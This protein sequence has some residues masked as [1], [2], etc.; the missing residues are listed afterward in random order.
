MKRKLALLLSA[1]MA[2]SCLPMTAYAANF[3]DIN[4]VPWS[5]AADV[6]NSVADLG[7]LSG[8]EDGT[9]RSRNN[10]TYCE[11]M[12]MVYNVLIK[13]GAA[14]AMDAVDAYSYM[15]VLN[16][17]KVPSWCQMAVAY[18]LH[19]GIID[20]QMVATKFSG[21]NQAATRE[22]VALIFGNAMAMFYD[23][24]KDAATAKEFLDYYSISADSLVQIDLLKRLGI[25]SGDETNRFNP[26]KNIN[27]AEMAVMLNKTNSVLTEGVSASG[28]ITELVVNENKYYYIEVT[29]D[30]GGREGFQATLGEF[31]VYVGNTSETISLSKLSEGDEVVLVRSGNNVTALRQLKGTTNQGKYD[32]TGYIISLKNNVLSFE[33]ENTGETTK[34]TLKSGVNI[35]VEGNK[36]TRAQLD[37]LLSERYNEHAYA[38]ANTSV[39]REKNNGVYEDVTYIEEL[40]V[41]FT[42]EYVT[43]GEVK[44]FGLKSISVKP[45]GGS[46][47]KTFTFASD[48]EFYIGDSKET[49]SDLKELNDGGTTY[50]KVTVNTDE[51]A[52]KV[53]MSEDAFEDSQKDVSKTYKVKTLTDKKL[54]LEAGGE[55]TTYV[56]GTTNPL[57]N[58]RFYEW[59]VDEDD[60]DDSD[61]QELKNVDK[62]EAFVDDADGT[63]YCKIVFNSG[64]KLSEVY[65]SEKKSAWDDSDENRTERKGTVASIV[66]DVLKFKTSSIEYTMKTKYADGDIKIGGSETQSKKLL[67]RMANDSNMEL[68]AEIVAN[69]N[70]EV[71]E[72]DARLTAAK[73]KL[74]E[75]DQE[76]KYIKIETSEGEYELKTLS[77]PKLT[78]EDEDY[79]TLDDIETSKYVGETIEL[80]FNTNG[81]VNKLTL[82]N[83][84]KGNGTVGKIKGVATA[85]TDGLKIK[86]SS[87]TYTWL[88]ESRT[89]LRV[90]SSPTESL[91]VVKKM[92]EDPDVEVYVEVTPDEKDR[93]ELIN[94]YVRKAEGELQSCDNNYVRI[95]TES[96]NKFSF[97]LPS[98]LNSCDVN[99]LDQSKLEDG[100]ADGKGYDVKLTFADDGRVSDIKDA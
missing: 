92:I 6:I 64:G 42:D 93:I 47:E 53:I 37:D 76:E 86:G 22:D 50:A 95:L 69:G 78:D 97:D 36:V 26:K 21:G 57:D 55:D 34:Y 19:N 82:E 5:G 3:K 27:R 49:V 99:G 90:Y 35:Y 18:G 28:T 40:Y 77:K 83:G 58:I 29:L 71:V 56:F 73:G 46:S 14:K 68:Y 9:I 72:V 23:K 12:Q 10:V 65:L 67:T 15:A 17:Y 38:G 11:A 54:T 4:D 74:V 43:T 100:K 45:T 20:M 51:K 33:N 79:F 60:K 30:A 32:M 59:V 41:T 96:G 81:V 88:S 24:E 89:T 87:K 25:V 66:D 48:C 8:Y 16:T 31:P 85:T 2:A 13:T 80:G 63:V 98:K 39:E 70:N 52:I 1:V 91:S 75:Y 44:D 94:V 61:W 84:Y 7:L 62:A